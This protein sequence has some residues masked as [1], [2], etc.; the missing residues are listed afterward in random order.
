MNSIDARMKSFLFVQRVLW[1]FCAVLSFSLVSAAC[2]IEG[3]VPNS[4]AVP[5]T[6]APGL[7]PTSA[8]IAAA[9]A[10]RDDTWVIGLLDQPRYL[11]PYQSS[12]GNQR[13]AAPVTELLFP[14]PI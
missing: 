10:V 12:P 3:G 4:T 2:A 13:T 6:P 8:E 5:T 11:T 9:N 1:R 14:S 7:A